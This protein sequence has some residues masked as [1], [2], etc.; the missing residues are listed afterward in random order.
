MPTLAEW[1]ILGLLVAAIIILIILLIKKP[2]TH[3]EDEL[4]NTRIEINNSTANAIQNLGTMLSTL[5]DHVSKQQSESLKMVSDSLQNSSTLTEQKLEYIRSALIAQV[6][7]LTTENSKKL[8]EI[9]NTVDEKLQK[10]LEDRI[11]KSFNLVSQRL[12]E[13]YK[14]LGEMQILAKDVSSLQRTLSNVKTRGTMGE[15]QLG[16]ILEQILS[17]DQY[18]TNFPTKKGSSERVEFA[19]KFPGEGTPVFLPI[20]AKFPLEDYQKLLDAYDTLNPDEIKS[21]L[22]FLKKKIVM[23]AKKIH[24]KYIDIPNTTD[25]AIMFL[26]VE[27]L[28]AEV[29]KSGIAENL[30]RDSK[31]MVAGP[32][33]MAA[34]L[35]SLHMGFSAI[36]IQKRSSEVWKILNEVRT[37]FDNFGTVLEQ[38]QRKITQANDDLDKLVGVRTRKIRSRLNK[39]PG[40]TN[41]SSEAAVLEEDEPD[42]EK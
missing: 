32:T 27:G 26:P 18:E 41:V 4:K 39:L 1:I 11:S 14:G 33:T 31:I 37:E 29:I 36:A 42:S 25:F 19:I 30:Q 22:E 15:T 24:D 23:E 8:D 3:F 13:V 21:C 28:Y 2:K 7:N 12:E 10:T 6:S 17:P 5:N 34:L 35:N 38:A 40:L 16:S 9:R 20:D